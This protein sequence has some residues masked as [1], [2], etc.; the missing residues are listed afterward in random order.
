MRRRSLVLMAALALLAPTAPPLR[1]AESYRSPE[2][3]AAALKSCAARYPDLVQLKTI[4]RGSGGSEIWVLRIAARAE[5]APDPDVRPAV[6]IAANV[7]GVHLLGTEAALALA[8]RLLAASAKDNGWA[9][10]LKRTTVYIAPLLNPDTARKT[11]A[12]PLA[13][14]WS[15]ARPVDAD[16]DGRDDEDGPDDLNKD[17]LITQMRVKDPAGR[18][19]PDPKEPRLMRLANPLKG[20]TGLYALYPEGLDNDG[21][22]A[23]NEDGPGGVEVHR[24]FPHDFDYGNPAAGRYPASEVETVA[25]LK[26]LSERGNI[27]MIL[28]FGTENTIL[29]Q[30]QTG[31]ARL[32]GDKVKVPRMFA[33]FLGLDPEAEY[34]IKEIV[35]LLKGMRIGGGME[36]TEDVVA[37]FL[38]L[39]PAVVIDRMDQ[40]L[41]EEVQKAY[42]ESLKAARSGYPEK[43]AKGVGKGAFAAYAYYQYGV[44]V[45]SLDLWSV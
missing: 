45:F 32:G 9:A 25:L 37:M 34:T 28:G 24:N 3:V 13:E 22:G 39:G 15:N 11:F 20:E 44:F 27:A 43:R 16:L 18:Y 26:F 6:F 36:I 21:D 10:F 2:D 33:G 14:A 38:G 19:L 4:G 23:Y 30:Q 7:E 35:D 41:F 5:G 42:K 1:T 31:Q 8:E 40:P 29:N 17:G 12:A